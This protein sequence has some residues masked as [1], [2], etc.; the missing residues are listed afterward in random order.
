MNWG[1]YLAAMRD[2]GFLGETLVV[3]LVKKSS[4]GATIKSMLNLDKLVLV[5]DITTIKMK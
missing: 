4:V 1:N 3:R 5:D 2:S